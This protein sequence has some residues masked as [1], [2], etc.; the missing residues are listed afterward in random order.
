MSV[1]QPYQIRV[2]GVHVIWAHIYDMR[3]NK[4]IIIIS[5]V[6]ATQVTTK[7]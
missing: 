5:H 6:G 4:I 3:K 1:A 7:E 2:T